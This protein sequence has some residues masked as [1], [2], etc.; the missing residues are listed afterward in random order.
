MSRTRRRLSMKEFYETR[1]AEMTS[2]EPSYFLKGEIF[3]IGYH[4]KARDQREIIQRRVK[5]YLAYLK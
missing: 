1:R 5:I 2:N 3:L 4:N